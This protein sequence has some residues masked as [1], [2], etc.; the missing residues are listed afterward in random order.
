MKLLV[1]TVKY[2]P[3]VYLN[4]KRQSTVGWSIANILL[5]L[6]GGLG[7]LLQQ[8]LDSHS[9]QQFVSNVPKLALALLSIT[10]DVVFIVQHYVLYSE[11]FTKVPT[12]SERI[13]SFEDEMNGIE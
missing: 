1:S 7:S 4:W 12:D 3:Q 5:D 9:V 11:G 6:G 2:I 8:I 13:P 10:F